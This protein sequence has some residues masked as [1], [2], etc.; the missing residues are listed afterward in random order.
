MW[1]DETE[2]HWQQEVEAVMTG[3]KEWRLQHPRASFGEIEAALDERLAKMRARMLQDLALASVAAKVSAASEE[4]RPRCPQCGGAL[5]ARGEEKRTL[6]TTYNQPV[7][8]RRSYAY[9]PAC[10][11]GLFPPRRGTKAVGRGVHSQS[12]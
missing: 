6:T 4:E 8:L 10:D 12:R 5:E 9:C 1:S 2:G 3:M 11:A 7:T